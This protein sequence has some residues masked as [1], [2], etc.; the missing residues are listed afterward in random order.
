M[1]FDFENLTEEDIERLAFTVNSKLRIYKETNSHD[2]L[3]DLIKFS[4]DI[5]SIKACYKG[6]EMVVLVL[7]LLF[8]NPIETVID[9][10][11]IKFSSELTNDNTLHESGVEVACKVNYTLYL[12]IKE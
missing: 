7:K 3:Q 10:I 9:K 4:Y 5:K 1:T 11:M 8:E 6:N 12:G 2:S